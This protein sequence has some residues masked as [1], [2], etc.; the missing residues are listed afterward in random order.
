MSQ[1]FK[2]GDVVIWW[3]QVPGGGYV[4]PVLS[5]VLGVTAK[6]V[7]IE[8]EDDLPDSPV[9]RYVQ[10]SSLQHHESPKK[11]SPAK[12]RGKGKSGEKAKPTTGGSRKNGPELLVWERPGRPEKDE[13][14]EERIMMEIVVDAYGPEERALGWYDYLESKLNVPF[15]ARCVEEREVSPLSVGDEVDVVGMPPER[16][17]EAE[18]FVSIPWGKRTLAVPLSQLKVVE[19]DEDTTEAVGDWQ[20]W[21]GRGYSF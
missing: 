7:K 12:D 6:R 13:T 18:M 2:P 19:A 4:F 5:K 8:A 16:D 15:R 3:K 14:R 9:V 17:C 10:P 1:T 20:Y 21:V 11:T